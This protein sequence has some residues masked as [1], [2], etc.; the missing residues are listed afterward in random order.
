[1]LLINTQIESVNKTERK[2]QILLVSF[3]DL[4][5]INSRI[6]SWVSSEFSN[7]EIINFITFSESGDFSLLTSSLVHQSWYST[8]L[9]ISRI[10]S[11]L[12]D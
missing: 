8:I 11:S 7:D 3:Y 10:A 2:N 6:L 5:M 1:M 9:W 12:T 4:K